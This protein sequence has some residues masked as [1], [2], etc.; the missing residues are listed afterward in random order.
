MTRIDHKEREISTK[1]RWY[2]GPHDRDGRKKK[3]NAV[4][5]PNATKM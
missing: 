1:T 2:D 4:L 5:F 3:K